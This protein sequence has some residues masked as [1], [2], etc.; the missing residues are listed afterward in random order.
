MMAF[1]V[2]VSLVLLISFSLKVTGHTETVYESC[3]GKY[4]H[5][6]VSLI[7][8]AEAE[9]K[10]EPTAEPE[11]ISSTITVSYGNRTKGGT[12]STIRHGSHITSSIFFGTI[13][14]FFMKI[15]YS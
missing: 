14:A 4:K 8:E 10:V 7:P 15:L 5:S 3:K 6:T 2:T 1:A 9:S 11:R 13:M 12:T